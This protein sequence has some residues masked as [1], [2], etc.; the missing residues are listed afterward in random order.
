MFIIFF[1]SNLIATFYKLKTRLT[2][3]IGPE[4]FKSV[5]S[6]EIEGKYGCRQCSDTLGNN[7]PM[8]CSK[9]FR[10]INLFLHYTTKIPTLQVGI[11]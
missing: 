6:S 4:F 5:A 11:L 3:I 9:M 1:I 10:A 8:I 2:E 7:P